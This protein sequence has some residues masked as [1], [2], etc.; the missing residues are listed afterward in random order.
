MVRQQWAD[1]DLRSVR[2]AEAG[3]VGW[4]GALAGGSRPAHPVLPV[5]VDAGCRQDAPALAHG[6]DLVLRALRPIPY[7]MGH[8]GWNMILQAVARPCLPPWVSD[9]MEEKEKVDDVR[10]DCTK[11]KTTPG[12]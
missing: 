8:I 4:A 7:W 1:S 12:S 9:V 5:R 3:D 11:G 2:S 6:S 10:H